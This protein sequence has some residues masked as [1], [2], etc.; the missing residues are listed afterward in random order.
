MWDPPSL[1]LSLR[2]VFFWSHASGGVRGDISHW[3]A[4]RLKSKP[5][6]RLSALTAKKCMGGK[7]DCVRL[8]L[9]KKPCDAVGLHF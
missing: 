2:Q 1:G 6:E 9:F 3:L 7:G 5:K 8:N 4:H